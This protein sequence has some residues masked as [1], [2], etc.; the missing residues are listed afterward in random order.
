M[1]NAGTFVM[2]IIITGFAL[3]GVYFRVQYKDWRRQRAADDNEKA[4]IRLLYP[5][6]SESS[7]QQESVGERGLDVA[8]GSFIGSP[9]RHSLLTPM[10]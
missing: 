9:V 2:F 6:H 3:C 4:R 5:V 1:I 8:N 7:H 10:Q